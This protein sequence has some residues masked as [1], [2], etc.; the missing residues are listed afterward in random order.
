MSSTNPLSKKQKAHL[1]QLARQAYNHMGGDATTDAPGDTASARFAH[2][3][4]A[5]QF[6]VTGLSSLRQCT[7]GHYLPLRAHF[8]HILGRDDQAFEDTIKAA[9][10]NDHAAEDDT[11]ERRQQ[12]Q[13]L[14]SETLHGTKYHT[15]YVLAIARNK[16]RKPSLTSLR[17]LTVTQLKQLLITIKNRAAADTKKAQA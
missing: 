17:P 14:I 12:L 2:W 13:H 1:A 3:R 10:E 6:E 8:N 7:Q 5:Q 16:F 15:G 11:P 9:P 4:H